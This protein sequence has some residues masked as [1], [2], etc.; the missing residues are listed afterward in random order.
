MSHLG[1]LPP[2]QA[3]GRSHCVDLDEP[4]DL[5]DTE[6]DQFLDDYDKKDRVYTYCH[7]HASSA[8]TG[9]EEHF[10]VLTPGGHVCKRSGDNATAFTHSRHSVAFSLKYAE[11]R[12]M[13]Q[14]RA[15]LQFVRD[16]TTRLNAAAMFVKDLEALVRDEYLVWYR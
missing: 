7:E 11:L 5:S 1:R 8:A 16:Y 15:Q 12:H 3:I 4:P 2:L 13:L 9:L 6:I 14:T 10:R